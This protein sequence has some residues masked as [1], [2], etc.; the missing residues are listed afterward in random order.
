MSPTMSRSA[1]ALATAL[2]ASPAA[3]QPVGWSE[4]QQY[5]SPAYQ[6][7]SCAGGDHGQTGAGTGYRPSG[8]FS[9]GY[10]SALD[11]NARPALA[12]EDGAGG[13]VNPAAHFDYRLA[14]GYFKAAAS[15]CFDLGGRGATKV[16]GSLNFFS[17]NGN[18][19]L[20][21]KALPYGLGITGVGYAPGVF[22]S[23]STDIKYGNFRLDRTGYGAGFEVLHP[24]SVNVFDG[25]DPSG[26]EALFGKE[27]E[28]IT[29]FLLSFDLDTADQDETTEFMTDTPAFG[30]DSAADIRYD[31][32]FDINSYN[33]K[34]GL[35]HER[36]R[37]NANGVVT[38]GFLRGTVGYS[39]VDV[40]AT[41]SIWA[42]GLGG[43]LNINNSNR[44]SED[45]GMATASFEA[46]ISR[47][48][49]NVSGGFSIA[50]EYG[51][52]PVLD[53]HRPDSTAG[54]VPLDPVIDIGGDWSVRIGGGF[55]LR[56]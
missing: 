17:L 48:K 56:F 50:A 4:M 31:T 21:N 36:H 26:S 2:L 53:Y 7:G 14:G 37:L 24:F 30:A 19:S 1:A 16:T 55:R 39:F 54:G 38:S 35:Q 52:V 33:L 43:A 29:S 23:A 5:I 6:V 46:G 9:F 11:E 25:P 13:L 41:D 3:A 49:G 34:V 20:M 40:D 44:I 12:T 47:T 18:D 8:G 32:S 15:S 10:V 22:V 51:S 42:S 45:D 28:R 27:I